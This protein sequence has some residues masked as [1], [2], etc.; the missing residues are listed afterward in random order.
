MKHS[1]YF[2]CEVQMGGAVVEIIGTWRFWEV[3]V[4][5][6]CNTFS[7]GVET[8]KLWLIIW[9]KLFKSVSTLH[10][11]PLPPKR[12]K[13]K[14]IWT[15]VTIAIKQCGWGC[16]CYIVFMFI[17]LLERLYALGKCMCVCVCVLACVCA[18]WVPR[19]SPLYLRVEWIIW[20]KHYTVVIDRAVNM[21]C[22]CAS[23]CIEDI[24]WFRY[25][26]LCIS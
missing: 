4:R 21:L 12:E 2:W 19:C 3:T 13:T 17:M 16:K 11:L 18:L 24:F 25:I 26:L 1:I 5:F 6:V 14:E 9:M 15:V 10:P 8:R 7:C 20:Y 23:W 22:I